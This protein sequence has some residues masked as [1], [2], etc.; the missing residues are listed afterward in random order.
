MRIEEIAFIPL[1]TYAT[2]GVGLSQRVVA[3]AGAFVL[4]VTASSGTTPT[5]DVDITEY[6]A[7]TGTWNVI[8]SFTQQ[9][10]AVQ[11]RRVITAIYGG[12]LRA[13]YTIGG[14][15]SPDFTF[16]LGFVGKAPNEPF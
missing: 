5:L 10:G 7:A 1:A 3:Q 8:D 2:S 13:E 4:N 12:T 14:T 9:V 11:E 15:A 6:D 16:A